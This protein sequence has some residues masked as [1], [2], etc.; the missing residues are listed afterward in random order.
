[1]NFL[2][3]VMSKKLLFIASIYR[4]LH[5]QKKVGKKD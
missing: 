4:N 1:V 2:L 3:D 5:K